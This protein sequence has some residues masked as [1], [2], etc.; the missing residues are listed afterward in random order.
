MKN[1]MKW[2]VLRQ[3]NQNVSVKELRRVVVITALEEMVPSCPMFLDMIKLELV[4]ALPSIMS[5]ETIFSSLNPINAATGRNRIQNRNSLLKLMLIIGPNS[6]FKSEN[7]K[8]APRPI[9]AS[10]EAQFPKYV[11]DFIIIGGFGALR[12]DQI[13]P[14]KM[15]RIIGLVIRFIKVFLNNPFLEDVLSEEVRDSIKTA[16][17]LYIG[18]EPTIIKATMAVES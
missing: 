15:P 13:R 11:S 4:V 8:L 5:A 9:R 7:S 12:R 18:T 14:A 2:R 16:T 1:Q 17:V 3:N 6:F 10:G